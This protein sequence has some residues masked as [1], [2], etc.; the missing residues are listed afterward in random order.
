M[1]GAKRRG[2]ENPCS[3]REPCWLSP[4]GDLFGNP[5]LKWVFNIIPIAFKVSGEA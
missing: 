5:N 3:Q 4:I 2:R 1:G